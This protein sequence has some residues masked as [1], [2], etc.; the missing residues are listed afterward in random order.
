M[1]GDE[2]RKAREAAGFTQENLAFE[3]R[4]HRT[5]ISIL[6]RNIKSPTLDV[7]SRICRVLQVPVSVLIRRAERAQSRRRARRTY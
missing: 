5:Y 4:L 1:I 6:E 7:L 2:L 3:A